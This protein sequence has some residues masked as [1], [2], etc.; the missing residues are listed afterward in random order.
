M[1]SSYFYLQETKEEDKKLVTMTSRPDS[2]DGQA[3]PLLGLNQDHE[4]QHKW[5]LHHCRRTLHS[6]EI[7]YRFNDYNS[8]DSQSTYPR[9]TQQFITASSGRCFHYSVVSG[10]VTQ[11]DGNL[12]FEYTNRTFYGNITIPLQLTALK[13]LHRSREVSTLHRRR[14]DTAAARD[15]YGCG[16]TRLPVMASHP[17][18]TNVPS[19]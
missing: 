8:E 5:V 2:P 18:S 15:A 7:A 16:P 9:F 19:Q 17:P 3:N 14:L 4:S 1:M 12:L 13:V 10:P 11:P 6:Q